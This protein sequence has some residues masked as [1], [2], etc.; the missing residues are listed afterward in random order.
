MTI[1]YTC[2]YHARALLI[3]ND[4]NTPD[5]GLMDRFL[6]EGPAEQ[7]ALFIRADTGQLSIHK[8]CTCEYNNEYADME[9]VEDFLTDSGSEIEA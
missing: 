2:S 1:I 9:G 6:A 4:T 8:D 7:S 5:L 3:D